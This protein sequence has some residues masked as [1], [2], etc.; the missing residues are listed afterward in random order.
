[1]Q[2]LLFLLTL[3]IWLV[4]CKKKSDEGSGYD[5]KANIAYGTDAQQVL[6]L[7]LPGNANA[8]STKLMILIHGGAWADG[9]KA[10]FDIYI[11]EL[12]RRLPDYAFANINYRLYTST[13]QNKFPAQE[14]D[15][16]AAVN[17]LLNKSA[18]YKYSKDFILLGASAGGHLALL[19]GYKYANIAKPKAIISFFGPTDFT[20]LYHNPG[21]PIV[22]T[23]LATI[24]GATPSQNAALYDSYSPVHFVTPQSPHTLLLHGGKDELVPV[25]QAIQLTDKLNAAKVVYEYIYYPT[26]GH[27]WTGPNLDDSFNKVEAFIRK[28]VP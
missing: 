22:P 6:D 19:Q 7:Y 13:G 28:H 3:T 9:D 20:D 1:M 12:Q 14:E 26:E 25:R 5:K 27:S 24:I 23:L 4:G 10:D 21:M 8:S 17:F 16:K 18:D 2:K 11:N 15:V